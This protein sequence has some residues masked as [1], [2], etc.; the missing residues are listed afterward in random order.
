MDKQKIHIIAITI[1]TGLILYW[2]VK[3]YHLLGMSAQNKT[4]SGNPFD[5]QAQ[6]GK[7]GKPFVQTDHVTV[8][9][10]TG[11]YGGNQ[12]IYMPL[13]GF[14]GYSSGATE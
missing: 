13:F 7:N 1:L 10:E 6:Y 4:P 5:A 11:A 9:F 14:V 2:I 3:H 8:S 12:N